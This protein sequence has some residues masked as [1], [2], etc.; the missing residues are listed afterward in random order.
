MVVVAGAG[1]A[2]GFIEIGQHWHLDLSPVATPR[3]HQCPSWHTLSRFA[4][5]LVTVVTNR[6]APSHWLPLPLTPI[7][8]LSRTACPIELL[9]RVL[10]SVLN[11]EQVC[12]TWRHV[13]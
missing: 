12:S 8:Q 1:G 6:I 2:G 13:T 3:P 4:S 9:A 10:A 5:W 11:G 7:D